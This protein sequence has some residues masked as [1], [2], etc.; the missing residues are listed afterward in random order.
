[1]KLCGF[2][3]KLWSHHQQLSA[4]VKRLRET[5]PLSSTYCCLSSLRLSLIIHAA[6]LLIASRIYVSVFHYLEHDTPQIMEPTITAVKLNYQFTLPVKLL[7]LNKHLGITVPKKPCIRAHRF[8]V[9][10]SIFTQS[11]VNCSLALSVHAQNQSQSS[12][13]KLGVSFE[14]SHIHSSA[15][16]DNFTELLHT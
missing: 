4:D 1:M 12:Q 7:S 16:D 10:A 3:S 6:Y 13:T 2:L 9:S 15:S 5:N 8:H 14:H 11:R